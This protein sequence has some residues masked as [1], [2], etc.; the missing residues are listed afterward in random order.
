MGRTAGYEIEL[1]LQAAVALFRAR[2]FL[3]VSVEEIVQATGLNRFAIYEK[4]GGKE[5]LFYAALDYYHDVL[6]RAELLGPLFEPDASLATVTDM[7]T[8]ARDAALAPHLRA[9]CMI[10]N[11]N[12]EL[13]GADARVSSAAKA[14][15]SSFEE[16]LIAALTQAARRGELSPDEPVH[17]RARYVALMIHAFFSLAYISRSTAAELAVRLVAEVESW[18]RPANPALRVASSR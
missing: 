11:A 13:R 17:E 2:G 4:F 15:M 9:G 18:R 10:V 14:V 1:V 3:S 5:G 7:L 12:T 16:A 6:V 8:N